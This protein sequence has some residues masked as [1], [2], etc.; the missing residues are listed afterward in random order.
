MRQFTIS[1]DRVGP[2][3]WCWVRIH[4]TI[5]HFEAA[6]TRTSP[7]HPKDYWEGCRGCFQPAPYRERHVDGEWTGRWPTNG[8]AGVLRL[9]EGHTTPEI[10]AHELVHAA[11]QIYRMNVKRGIR[12]GEDC[13]ERE[14]QLAYI[15][16]ELFT[17]LHEHHPLA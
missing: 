16:G 15:Y 17:S 2:R 1:T 10:M 11:A 13:G 12:L 14:E 8:Y 6:A 4:P 5:T 9:I 7:W 3:R